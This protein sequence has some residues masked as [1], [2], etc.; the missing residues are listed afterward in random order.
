MSY[1]IRMHSS[2]KVNLMAL[3]M[4]DFTPW[5]YYIPH[6]FVFR[7]WSCQVDWNWLARKCT[8][9]IY[10]GTCWNLKWNP[11]PWINAKSLSIET[12]TLLWS[13]LLLFFLFFV[14]LKFQSESVTGYPILKL[15]DSGHL[16]IEIGTLCQTVSNSSFDNYQLINIRLEM[17]LLSTKQM[18]V[19]MFCDVQTEF[20]KTL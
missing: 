15:H 3:V 13:T 1:S 7:W 4:R 8:S 18:Y 17:L 12:R 19:T 9:Q 5:K 10:T 6:S 16:G 2:E 20:D 11:W 14:P